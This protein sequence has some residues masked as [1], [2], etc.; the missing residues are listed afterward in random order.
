MC[1]LGS[2]GLKSKMSMTCILTPDAT[3]T[4]S[5]PLT[6]LSPVL[7]TRHRYTI[8]SGHIQCRTQGGGG[9]GGG[10]WGGGGQGTQAH[11]PIE[12]VSTI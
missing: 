1:T 9:G 4:T 2:V 12:V 3:L 11:T 6:T 10:G 5:T 8:F 7:S